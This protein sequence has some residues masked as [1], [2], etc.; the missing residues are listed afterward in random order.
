[1]SRAYRKWKE[2]RSM[3][4]YKMLRRVRQRELKKMKITS[5]IMNRFLSKYEVQQ[6]FYTPSP[7][8]RQIDKEYKVNE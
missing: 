7:E 3:A 8:Y 1:M 5:R 6:M 2:E 4:A